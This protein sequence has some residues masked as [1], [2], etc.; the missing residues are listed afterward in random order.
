M[1]RVESARTQRLSTWSPITRL[2]H[3]STAHESL[4]RE[5]QKGSRVTTRYSAVPHWWSLYRTY[6]TSDR[7]FKWNSYN[8]F[9]WP[10][11]ARLLNADW[12]GDNKM[13]GCPNDQRDLEVFFASDIPCNA[14][15]REFCY[16]VTFRIVNLF[17]LNNLLFPYD[18]SRV[19]RLREINGW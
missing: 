4:W 3:S 11:N 5:M 15:S 12:Y 6:S 16:N 17:R 19:R 14:T 2:R 8:R 10:S 9:K 18:F 7:E 13:T 1:S